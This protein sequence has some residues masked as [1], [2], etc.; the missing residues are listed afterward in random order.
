MIYDFNLNPVYLTGKIYRM[1]S[2]KLPNLQYIGSTTVDINDR[3]RQHRHATCNRLLMNLFKKFDDVVIELIE[4]YPCLNKTQLNIR[5]QFYIN[6]CKD[7]HHV[8]INLI[9]S[10]KIIEYFIPKSL[11]QWFNDTHPEYNLKI[12]LILL[13]DYD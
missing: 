9:S 3:L 12:Q 1:F 13:R 6:Q 4:D 11:I 8:I 10:T 7:E 2:K 5:E